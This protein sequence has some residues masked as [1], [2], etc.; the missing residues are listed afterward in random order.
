MGVWLSKMYKNLDHVL[1][2]YGFR[3]IDFWYFQNIQIRVILKNK[4]SELLVNNLII[5]TKL[6]SERQIC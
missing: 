1:I 4:T 3:N 5:T 6:H 2:L